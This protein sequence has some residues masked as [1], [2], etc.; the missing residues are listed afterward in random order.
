MSGHDE[1]RLCESTKTLVVACLV[2]LAEGFSA[3]LIL[4]Y[5]AFM[6]E[7]LRGTDQNIGTMTGVVFAVYSIGSF[8]TA[9]VWANASNRFG[10]K[11]CCMFSL[12]AGAAL[13]LANAFCDSFYLLVPLRLTMG[14]VNCS[15]PTVRT[16]L[17]ER[18]AALG[19]DETTAFASLQSAFALSALLGPGLG[20][21][22]YAHGP[23]FLLPWFVPQMLALILYLIALLAVACWM[24]ETA[25]LQ[26][27]SSAADE[28]ADLQ[29]SKSGQEGSSPGLLGDRAFRYLLIMYMGHSFVFTG[30]QVGYPLFAKDVPGL[31]WSVPEIGFTFFV[32]S[33]GLVLYSLLLLRPLEKRFGLNSLWFYS[34]L[35][36][37]AAMLM[38]PRCVQY[39]MADGHS[40]RSTVV[41]VVNCAAQLLISVLVGSGFVTLQLIANRLVSAR[42]DANS[43]LPLANGYFAAIQALARA[44]SPMMTGIAFASARMPSAVDKSLVFDVL[45]F[46][47]I[48]CCVIAG[49]LFQRAQRTNDM[50]VSYK[51]GLL[52]RRTPL[53]DDIADSYKLLTDDIA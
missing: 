52:F 10:R 50:P 45:A 38:F 33:G 51:V 18:V 39:L 46:I 13:A 1:G 34:W 17:R 14:M 31:G 47:S 40:S 20:G 12:A 23:T 30:W 35:P 19:F 15:L 32:G 7:Y 11:R 44:T 9:G 43:A 48:V 26:S 16:N 42:H 4:P 27:K 53:T 36:S 8:I 41:Q 25:D 21:V 29:R 6:V 37:I 49:V 5:A 28:R 24:V 22:L 3:T 2:M